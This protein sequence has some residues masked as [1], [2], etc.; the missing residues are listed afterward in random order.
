MNLKKKIGNHKIFTYDHELFNFIDFF[1]K[2]Y[3]NQDLQNI[4][5]QSNDYNQYKDRLDLGILNDSQTDLHNIFYDKIKNDNEFK[6]LYCNFIQYIYQNFYPN[7]K[8]ILYQSFPSIR[9]QY[10][11]SVSIPSHKDSD[12]LSNHPLGE[13]NFLIPITEMKNTN[14]IYIESE[15]DKKDFVSIHL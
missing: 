11:E 15:P 6:I 13:K 2:I 10:P 7:E 8:Y 9:I 3:K 1:K 5:L 4:H 14:S 12:S